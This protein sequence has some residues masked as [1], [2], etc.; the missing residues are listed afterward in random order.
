MVNYRRTSLLTSFSKALENITCG[1]FLHHINVNNIL[2]SEQS[3]FQTKSSTEKTSF[4]LHND[5]LNALN[6]KLK[7]GGIFLDSEKAFDCVN[8]DIL[9]SKLK[10]NGVTNRENLS[11]N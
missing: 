10:F 4:K 1:R 5:T 2:V 7:V 9:L 6:N 3:E 11:V 8:H